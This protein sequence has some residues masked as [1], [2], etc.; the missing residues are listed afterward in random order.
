MAG[1]RCRRGGAT[2]PSKG[3]GLR[4]GTAALALAGAPPSS[5]GLLIRSPPGLPSGG[6][7]ATA[8]ARSEAVGEWAISSGERTSTLPDPR[9]SSALARAVESPGTVDE[10]KPTMNADDCDSPAG[11][12]GTA[13]ARRGRPVPAAPALAPP[14]PAM[15]VPTSP[16][17]GEWPRTAAVGLPW[18]RN[19]ATRAGGCLAAPATAPPGPPAAALGRPSNAGSWRKALGRDTA[20]AVPNGT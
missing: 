9:R 1:S 17:N 14:P 10:A 7:A 4:G 12:V 5:F 15:L 19:A 20:P 13:P 8:A 6:W 3:T 16:T 11:T 2:E 18:A